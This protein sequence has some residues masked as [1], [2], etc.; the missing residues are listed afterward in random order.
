MSMPIDSLDAYLIE[1]D[2]ARIS[3]FSWVY[4]YEYLNIFL[5]L[6]DERFKAE[7]I[8]TNNQSISIH[9]IITCKE[10]DVKKLV[11]D[12]LGVGQML[13]NDSQGVLTDL[14]MSLNDLKV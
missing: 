4:R 9:K 12:L 6:E 10:S 1:Q 13:N 5:T 14:E 8:S 3:S 2:F 7:F 11:P